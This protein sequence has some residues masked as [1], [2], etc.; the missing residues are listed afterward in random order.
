MDKVALARRLLQKM[1]EKKQAGI[2]LPLAA[3]AALVGGAHIVGK[4]MNKAKEYKAGF[5]PGGYGGHV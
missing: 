2:M 4:G 3:G 5:Q 1:A